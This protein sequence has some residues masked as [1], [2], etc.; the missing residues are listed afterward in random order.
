MKMTSGLRFCSGLNKLTVISILGAI[1]IRQGS[2]LFGMEFIVYR[3]TAE[4]VMPEGVIQGVDCIYSCLKCTVMPFDISFFFIVQGS[5]TD[6]EGKF[7]PCYPSMFSLI[8]HSRINKKYLFS[9]CGPP[10]KG[11][12]IMYG[13]HPAI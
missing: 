2:T 5:Q 10:K 4:V 1:T 7:Q 12:V 13:R 9:Y 11:S 6:P 3:T 8:L